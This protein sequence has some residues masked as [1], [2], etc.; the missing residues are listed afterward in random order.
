MISNRLAALLLVAG[1]LAPA[2][3]LAARVDV[4][5]FNGTSGNFG[6]STLHSADGC[7]LNGYWRCGSQKAGVVG[8][9]QADLNGIAFTNITGNVTINAVS[10]AVSGALD[11][12]VAA[13]QQIGSLT[14]G[15]LGTFD[16]M[17]LRHGTTVANTWDPTTGLLYLWGQDFAPTSTAPAGGLGIDLGANVA[18]IPEPTAALVFGLGTLLVASGKRRRR[19]RHA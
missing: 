7:E 1:L 18:P 17:N 8:L 4:T 13:G 5:L 11:F 6:H 16:F 2:S 15:S 10:Y 19:L 3:A 12:G 9:L 14:I